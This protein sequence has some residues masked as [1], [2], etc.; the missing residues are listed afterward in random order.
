MEEIPD[1][2]EIIEADLVL[3][4]MG[5]LGP[6]AKLAQALNIETDQRSNFKADFGEYA[7]S[8]EG[9]FAAGDCRRGQSLVVWAIAEGRQA[10]EQ[11]NNYLSR[12]REQQANQ[13]GHVVG[14]IYTLEQFAAT[15]QP[16]AQV[17]A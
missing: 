1:S 3:L 14:G 17:V 9:V 11:I 7:T 10:A 8:I 5:F 2:A 12:N 15:E 13:N 6:E 16:T 4:A